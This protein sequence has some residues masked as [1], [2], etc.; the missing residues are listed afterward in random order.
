MINY[1]SHILFP[2]FAVPEHNEIHT[3][4]AARLVIPDLDAAV[5]HYFTRGLAP[6]T[7][8]TYSSGI[9]KYKQFC[10]Q[11]NITSPIPV[12]QSLLCY[13]VAYLAT[14]GLSPATIKTYLAAVC[15]LQIS[16][17]LSDRTHGKTAL[18]GSRSDK[19]V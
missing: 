15:H 4:V 17:D 12:S 8:R 7:H 2:L 19:G 14:A 11:F 16:L 5:H 18:G 10:N 9:N 1:S 6:S 13:F 3:A